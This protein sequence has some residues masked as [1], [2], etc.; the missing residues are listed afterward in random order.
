MDNEPLQEGEFVGVFLCADRI[1]IRQID[2]SNAHH[3]VAGR[4][5]RLDIARL[6]VVL[7]SRQPACDLE[8]ALGE[9]GDAIERLLAVRLDVVAELLDLHARELL[10]EALDF[11]Q[12]KNVG[13]HFLQVR[14]EVGS[15]CRTEL[16]FQVAM[17]KRAAP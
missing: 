15:R 11:L 1:A 7:I 14:K 17:R 4:N 6:R 2:A 13:L 10:V 16:T 9:N 8:R 12:A 5:D 3:A